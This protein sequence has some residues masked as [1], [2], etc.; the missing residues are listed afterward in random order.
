M[1]KIKGCNR[2]VQIEA[3]V[4]D[5]GVGWQNMISGLCAKNEC[6]NLFL[7][8]WMRC[9]QLQASLLAKIECGLPLRGDMTAQ[10]PG[11]SDQKDALIFR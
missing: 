9:E 11:M 8:L 2:S 4:Q 6:I 7:Q 10:H 1:R 3:A 5:A